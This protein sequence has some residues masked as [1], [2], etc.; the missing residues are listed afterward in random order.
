MNPVAFLPDLS[1]TSPIADR[2]S[3]IVGRPRGISLKELTPLSL[4]DRMDTKYLIHQDDLCRAL[5]AAIHDYTVLEINGVR[6]GRYI[7][8]YFDTPDF[9]MYFAH[10]DGERARFKLRCRSYLD[11]KMVFIE[12]KM[13]NN[14]ERL[15]KF[16]RQVPEPITSFRQVK[17]D[18]LPEYFHYP[19]DSVHP[20]V[21]NRFRRVTLANFEKQ[22]R[23]TIDVDVHF[24][25]GENTFTYD[26]LS[27][28]EVKQTKFS[29][30]RSPLAQQLHRMHFNPMGISKFCIAATHYYPN[31]KH[32]NFKP[33]LLYMNRRFELRGACERPV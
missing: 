28:V 32:N 23:V 13:K 16:R 24:G 25:C 22:E 12:V 26:G 20:V 11:S 2:V 31:F 18:W 6:P 9:D 1:M 29:P 17:R 27:V 5:E 14:K 19:F 4:L 21:W 8:T 33:L 7:T 3:E 15:I 30:T 10:H